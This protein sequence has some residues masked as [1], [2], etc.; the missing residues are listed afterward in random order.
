MQLVEL[1]NSSAAFRQKGINVASITYDSR[2][3]LAG[4]AATYRIQYPMLSDAGSKVI[5]SFGILNTNIP[6]DHPMMYGIPFPG[7]FL[8][9][10]DGVVRDKRFLP[11]YQYRPTAS[12]VLLKNFGVGVGGSAAEIRTEELAA[13]VT[14]SSERAFTGQE[15]AVVVKFSLKSGWHIYGQPLPAQYTATSVTFDDELLAAQELEFPPARPMALKALGETLPVY[16]GEF[17]A[18]GRLRLRWSPPAEIRSFGLGEPIDPGERKLT[19]TLRFQ[20]CNDEVCTAPRAVRFE[21]PLRIEP[22]V[23]PARNSG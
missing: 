15:L 11:D 1:Q 2:E 22:G 7:D 17:R 19:G 23:P 6:E 8:L 9:G 18:Q 13:E 4:F 3:A 16:E 10:P 21:I 20:A 5:R 12:E 14:L